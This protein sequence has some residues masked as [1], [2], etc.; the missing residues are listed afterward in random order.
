MEKKNEIFSLCLNY[1]LNV[2]TEHLEM[3]NITRNLS[4]IRKVDIK[5][6]GT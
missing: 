1:D 4:L 6:K 2:G 3:L 5:V